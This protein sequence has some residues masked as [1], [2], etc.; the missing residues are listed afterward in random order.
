MYSLFT[1]FGGLRDNADICSGKQERELIHSSVGDAS[2]V[3][4]AKIQEV[5]SEPTGGDASSRRH[6]KAHR[7]DKKSDCPLMMPTRGRVAPGIG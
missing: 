6:K 5:Y 1:L 2:R 3:G 7:T 4:F